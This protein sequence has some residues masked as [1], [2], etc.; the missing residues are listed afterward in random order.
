MMKDKLKGKVIIIFQPAEEGVRGAKSI[1]EN[2]HL[3]GVDYFLSSHITKQ[4][5]NNKVDIFPGSGEALATSKLYVKI[6][7]KSSHAAGYPEEGNNTALAM[8]TCILNLY[9]IPRHSKGMTR[10]NVGLANAGSGRN[11]IADYAY[12]QIETRG[13]T[14]EINEYVRSY[15]ENIIKNA[16]QMHNCKYQISLEGE[17]GSFESDIGLMELISDVADELGLKYKDMRLSLS[18]SEDVSYMMEEVQ[19]QGGKADFIR[20]V[21]EVDSIAHNSSYDFNEEVI[22]KGVNVFSLALYKLLKK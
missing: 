19:K 11:V 2:G 9:S 15:A 20:L 8:A 6:Y 10:I 17:A 18:G 12:M 4:D 1:V 13:E 3:K 22:E 7:G 5:K 14:S 21:T 16:C